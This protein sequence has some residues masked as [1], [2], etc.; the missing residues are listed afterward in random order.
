M[1]VTNRVRSV[2]RR[3]RIGLRVFRLVVRGCY[4]EAIAVLLGWVTERGPVDA[5]GPGRQGRS[6]HGCE[7]SKPR[8]FLRR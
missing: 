5:E 1:G 8:W 3:V 2:C 6:S 4:C 7:G